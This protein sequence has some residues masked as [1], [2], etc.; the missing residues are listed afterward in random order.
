M[1]EEKGYNGWKNYQTWCISLWIGNEEFLYQQCL[2]ITAQAIKD[3][4]SGTVGGT[5]ATLLKDFIW[6]GN[7][8]MG[9]AT[10]WADLLGASFSSVD[11]FEIASHYIEDCKEEFETQE[12]E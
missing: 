7:P 4:S 5:V 9:K 11:W 12:E 3:C 6:Q 8:L 1:T 10:M 2:E